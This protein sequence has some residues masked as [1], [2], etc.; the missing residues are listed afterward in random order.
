MPAH[1]GVCHSAPS[2]S[3][4]QWEFS[5]LGDGSFPV[6]RLRSVFG[7]IYGAVI[8]VEIDCVVTKGR[9][10]NLLDPELI[11]VVMRF[12]KRLVDGCHHYYWDW[13]R[14]LLSQRGILANNWF[15][16]TA[17]WR[18]LAMRLRA[19]CSRAS[20]NLSE[21]LCEY[22][23]DLRIKQHNCFVAG[24]FGVSPK[25]THLPDPVSENLESVIPIPLHSECIS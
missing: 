2:P 22:P 19:R 20:I 18:W 4:V 25:A 15:A 13:H 3:V 8:L 14:A 21:R 7:S 6:G 12:R 17:I 5:S 23:T 24:G 1:H 9:S 10:S 11:E 16:I